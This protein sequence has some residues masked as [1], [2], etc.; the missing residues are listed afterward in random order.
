MDPIERAAII[1]EGYDPDDPAVLSALAD[2][3]RTLG[4]HR[5][6]TDEPE[7]SIDHL[8]NTSRS[9]ESGCVSDECR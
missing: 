7:L 9:F 5:H 3:V 6:I 4:E 1:D 8:V 2:V